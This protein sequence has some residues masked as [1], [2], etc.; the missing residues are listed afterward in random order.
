MRQNNKNI[1]KTDQFFY[2][3]IVTRKDL[4][5]EQQTKASLA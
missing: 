1:I 3:K 4:T 5:V 2:K